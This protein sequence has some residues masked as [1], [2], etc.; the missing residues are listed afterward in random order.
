MCVCFCVF[1]RF[2]CGRLFTSNV[3]FHFWRCVI[4]CHWQAVI[5]QKYVQTKMIWQRMC[6]S[7]SKSKETK[8]IMLFRA[9]SVIMARPLVD[10]NQDHWCVHSV[11]CRCK[12]MFSYFNLYTHR[13]RFFSAVFGEFQALPE[14][15]LFY[16]QSFELPTCVCVCVCARVCV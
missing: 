16:A 4:V 14:V 12:I 9:N 15:I 3:S 8:I 6:D 5:K 11:D 10:T 13:C 1:I 7:G 2:G